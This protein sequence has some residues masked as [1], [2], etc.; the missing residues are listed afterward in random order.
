M[1]VAR[2][3]RRSWRILV[4]LAASLVVAVAL[5]E[6]VLAIV[7]INARSSVQFIPGKG[8]TF[9]PNAYYRHSREGFSEGRFNSHG[10]RDHERTIDKP[11]GTYRIAVF[12]DSFTEAFQV[13]LDLAFPA[14][15]ER[16]LGRR[17]PGARVE[18]LA[19]GQSGFGTADSLMRYRNFGAAY[20]PDLVLLA[21]TTI[22][23]YRNNHRVLN[24]DNVAYYFEVGDDG[25][26]VL[27]TSRIDDYAETL[28]P[29]KRM[30]QQLKRRSYLLSLIAEDVQLVREHWRRARYEDRSGA[31]AT[32]GVSPFSD[33]NVY[34][35]GA[36]P[37][38]EEAYDLTARILELFKR[39]VES[40]G[41]EFALIALSNDL[42]THP[43]IRTREEQKHGVSFDPDLPDD[44]LQAMAEAA[45]IPFLRL[46][47]RLLACH[48]D[49]GEFL[50][51]FRNNGTGHWNAE[52][53][54]CAADAI[55]DYLL[56]DWRPVGPARESPVAGGLRG[57]CAGPP[58]G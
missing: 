8:P 15:V 29:V 24:R 6:I 40:H 43:A 52:G 28:N 34:L 31:H 20:S 57:P 11:A 17:C 54:R 35:E 41:G 21:F 49:G 51:G 16:E 42:Q 50:H 9:L 58:A 14:R 25:E 13:D 2:K 7:K 12:G 56:E 22:N 4:L 18:V 10:F 32:R 44:R 27:D 37:R 55:T 47:P 3:R 33:L 38:W 23:D 53:H 5:A 1:T 19:F 26:L 36:D 39:D 46:A 30:Y 48:L 45:G